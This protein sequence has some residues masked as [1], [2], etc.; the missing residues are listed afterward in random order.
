MEDLDPGGDALE[1]VCDPIYAVANQNDAM[2]AVLVHLTDSFFRMRPS[3][4]TF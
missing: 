3:F 4:G 2:L 1:A